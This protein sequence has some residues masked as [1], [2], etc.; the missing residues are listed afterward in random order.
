[1][2]FFGFFLCRYA[3]YCA[4]CAAYCGFAAITHTLRAL[5]RQSRRQRT[6]GAG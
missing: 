5:L 1:M 4:L 2:H 6:K 3:R